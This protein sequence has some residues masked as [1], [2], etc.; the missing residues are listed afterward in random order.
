MIVSSTPSLYTMASEEA[1]NEACCEV[2]DAIYQ[3]R[4]CAE[5][6]PGLP[7]NAPH[8]LSSWLLALLTASHISKFWGNWLRALGYR[9]VLLVCTVGADDAALPV[10]SFPSN[11]CKSVAYLFS[12]LKSWHWKLFVYLS[13]IRLEDFSTWWVTAHQRD[14]ALLFKSLRPFD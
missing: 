8:L 5:L 2:E 4:R 3:V 9:A 13:S 11:S 6:F 1:G 10:C 7:P 14:G 12:Y